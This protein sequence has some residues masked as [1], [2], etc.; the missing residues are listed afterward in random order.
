MSRLERPSLRVDSRRFAREALEET[1]AYVGV[2]LA[3]HGE[4]RTLPLAT[5]GVALCT[6]LSGRV[7]SLEADRFW[8]EH[9]RF[10]TEVRC[11]LP[12]AVDL[13][14]LLHTRVHLTVREEL[15]GGASTID[16]RIRDEDG[17]L[18]LWA[19]DGL[20]PDGDTPCG[21]RVL[22][23]VMGCSLSVGSRDHAS[24]RLPVPGIVSVPSAEG[25]LLGLGLR[26]QVEGA[27]FLFLRA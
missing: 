7:T 6:Q 10:R 2:P 1:V 9:E 27:A 21:L 23:D 5:G 14:A 19:R 4:T 26:A 16:A 25:P 11:L 18:I 12:G 20:L 15:R 24:V 22:V 13:S 3:S 8:L 17:A